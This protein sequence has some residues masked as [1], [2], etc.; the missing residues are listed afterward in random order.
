M[1]H[2]FSWL[3]CSFRPLVFLLILLSICH[4]SYKEPFIKDERITCMA[5]EMDAIMKCPCS[6]FGRLHLVIW[7]FNHSTEAVFSSQH[8][9]P[10]C[11]TIPLGFCVHAVTTKGIV[12]AKESTAPFDPLTSFIQWIATVRFRSC[13]LGTQLNRM[14]GLHENMPIRFARV[15]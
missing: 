11:S 10:P 2:V 13:Q 6:C 1:Y 9:N 12:L 8:T 7:T 15:A 5:A 14:V 4:R 3:G